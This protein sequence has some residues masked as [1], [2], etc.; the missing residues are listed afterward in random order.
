MYVTDTEA[1]SIRKIDLKNG[2]VTTAFGRGLFIFGDKDGDLKT[3]LLQHNVG[4]SEKNGEIF[5]ADTYN[6][7]IKKINFQ[8][9]QLSTVVAG[10]NEPNDLFFIDDFMFISDTNNHHIIKINLKT[11]EKTTIL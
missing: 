5:V 11:N 2:Q 6:G 7:K 10:L 8:T 3:A 9:N 1:S 4:I